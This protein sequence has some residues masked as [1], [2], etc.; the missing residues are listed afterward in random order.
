MT[1][2]AAIIRDRTKAPVPDRAMMETPNT[3]DKNPVRT[4][5]HSAPNFLRKRIA[6]MTSRT[7]V[8]VAQIAM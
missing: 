8:V 5:S 6:V 1:A 7:P 3:T 2:Y 4:S